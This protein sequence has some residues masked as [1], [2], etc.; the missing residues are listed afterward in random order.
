MP[1]KRSEGSRLPSRIDLSEFKEPLE[2]VLKYVN[3]TGLDEQVTQ[4]NQVRKRYTGVPKLKSVR[5]KLDA[6]M[7]AL[8]V[9]NSHEERLVEIRVQLSRCQRIADRQWSAAQKRVMSRSSLIGLPKKDQDA[10]FDVQLR[11]FN[12]VCSD[13][14]AKIEQ[15]DF[16]L[17]QVRNTSFNLKTMISTLKVQISA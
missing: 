4:L 3:D 5:E 12:E 2:D 7:N 15:T 17:E 11:Y 13:V 1:P 14:S 9:V 6:L 8:I 16:V 10:I